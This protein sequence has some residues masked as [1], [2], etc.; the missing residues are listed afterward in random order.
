MRNLKPNGLTASALVHMV[1][2][3]TL[4]AQ[5]QLLSSVTQAVLSLVEGPQ[6]SKTKL[7]HSAGPLQGTRPLGP[8]L[9]WT[10]AG[11]WSLWNKA[12]VST[13]TF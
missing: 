3:S 12:V 11:I 4:V 10:S 6:P 13:L 5:S 1:Q 8:A 9:L 2:T 7:C